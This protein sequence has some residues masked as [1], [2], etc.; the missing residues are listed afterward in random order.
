MSSLKWPFWTG[1][2]APPIGESKRN[3]EPPV[4]TEN[5]VPCG[6]HVTRSAA[7]TVIVVFPSGH[8]HVTNEND[9]WSGAAMSE[10]CVAESALWLNVK[11]I[12]LPVPDEPA[13]PDTTWPTVAAPMAETRTNPN[14]TLTFAKLAL[15]QQRYL[16]NYAGTDC[17]IA[18]PERQS[19]RPGHC[20]CRIFGPLRWTRDRPAP[21]LCIRKITI[22]T[23]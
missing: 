14:R 23:N 15:R 8:W 16:P 4:V 1:Y 20:D 6:K 10:P 13:A 18:L 22:D 2:L 21:I 3:H 5:F 11:V 12:G 9:F 7:A 19:N 17:L